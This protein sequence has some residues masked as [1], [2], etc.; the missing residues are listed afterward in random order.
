MRIKVEPCKR[1]GMGL[2]W[3]TWP[4]WNTMSCETGGVEFIFAAANPSVKSAARKQKGPVWRSSKSPRDRL[5]QGS[6]QPHEQGTL[7]SP[8]PHFLFFAGK[9]S[10]F[11]CSGELRISLLLHIKGNPSYSRMSTVEESKSKN[12]TAQQSRG[13]TLQSSTAGAGLG[14]FP[15]ARAGWQNAAWS[16]QGGTRWARRRQNEKEGTQLNKKIKKIKK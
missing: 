15:S 14:S 7:T 2:F 9:T 1:Q 8:W 6:S 16:P 4:G 10:T 12:N 3:H 11:S 5:Q 13:D